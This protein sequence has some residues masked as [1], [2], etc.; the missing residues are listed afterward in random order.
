MSDEGGGG[1]Q[2]TRDG[3]EALNGTLCCRGKATYHAMHL[4]PTYTLAVGER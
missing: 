1:W 4:Q 3:S 2:L